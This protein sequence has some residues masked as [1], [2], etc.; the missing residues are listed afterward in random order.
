M[1]KIKNILHE[2]KRVFPLLVAILLAMIV[3]QD[4]SQINVQ[5]YALSMVAFVVVFFHIA[6][7]WMFPYIDLEELVNIAKRNQISSA[8][9]FASIIAFLIAV[10]HVTVIH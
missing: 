4:S 6:R 8:I 5:L 2:L 7:Q 3:F 10:I 1:Q 9:I